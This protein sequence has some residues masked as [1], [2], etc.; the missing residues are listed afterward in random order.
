MLVIRKKNEIDEDS[1]FSLST[2]YNIEQYRELIFSKGKG[3]FYISIDDGYS[4][5]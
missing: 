5:E 2:V 3:S 4:F 1:F